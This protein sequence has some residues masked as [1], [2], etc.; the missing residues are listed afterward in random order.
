MVEG[1]PRVP[2]ERICGA[3]RDGRLCLRPK[4]HKGDHDNQGRR[5]PQKGR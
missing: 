3:R 2:V 1:K 4:G 5:W